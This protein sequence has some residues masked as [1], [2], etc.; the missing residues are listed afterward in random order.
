MT[1][2][3]PEGKVIPSSKP[4]KEIIHPTSVKLSDI[5]FAEDWNR[6]KIGNIRELTQSIKARGLLAPLVVRPHP[7]KAG[8]Y[9]LIDGRRRYAV[10]KD[11]E[12]KEANVFIDVSKEVKDKTTDL[13]DSTILN[14]QREDN[15]DYEKGLVYSKLIAE[16]KKSTE[17]AK[18]FG[19]KEAY[20]S[21][22]LSIF[23]LPAK[24]QN[25]VKKE[26]LTATHSRMFAAYF[27]GEDEGDINIANQMLERILD[28]T[29]STS[30]AQERLD[31]YIAK[32][33]AKAAAK[34]EKPKG[35]VSKGA[36][37]AA[38]AKKSGKNVGEVTTA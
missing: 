38:A 31:K 6:E 11:L 8:K 9:I 13:R 24:W 35:K 18:D 16:G 22:R 36:K 23:K 28:G 21:Q 15:T 10:L 3:N 27:T 12:I 19:I 29:L 20:V 5:V 37:K 14:S 26:N 1:E 32:K 4:E 7:T 34:E 2:T 17:I 30:E 25:E 33:E